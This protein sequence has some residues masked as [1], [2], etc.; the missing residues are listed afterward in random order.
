MKTII[1]PGYSKRNKKW[2]E[3]M[4][5]KMGLGHEIVVH[6][7]RHWSEDKSLSFKYEIEKI[8]KKVGSEKFNIISKSVGTRVALRLMA[9]VPER[10]SKAVLTG[11]AS[12]GS[13][14]RKL[15]E[16]ALPDFPTEK[17]LVIQNEDDP[18]ADYDSVEKL[19]QSIKPET[20]VVRKESDKHHYP[21]P[22]EFEKFL[23][24]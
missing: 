3:S 11:F 14:M 13:D 19:I 17:L 8:L 23:M 1:L 2:A 24:K 12:T 22:D 10:I 4:A 16:K 6:N 18:Y 15:T 7:W 9:E 20:E 21:Y 5:Q